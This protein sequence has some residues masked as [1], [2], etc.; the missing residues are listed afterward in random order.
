[1]ETIKTQGKW[2]GVGRV[3]CAHTVLPSEQNKNKKIQWKMFKRHSRCRRLIQRKRRNLS[4]ATNRYIYRN[5]ILFLS[6]FLWC[7]ATKI[8]QSWQKKDG[9]QGFQF[10]RKNVLTPRR[11]FVANENICQIYLEKHDC[12]HWTYLFLSVY[13]ISLAYLGIFGYRLQNCKF[14]FRLSFSCEFNSSFELYNSWR[15]NE[16]KTLNF[17]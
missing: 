1:M 4:I 2:H 3:C 17:G 6:F 8:Y 13:W 16:K 5:I 10:W 14:T 7:S 9:M 15:N 11:M 12:M